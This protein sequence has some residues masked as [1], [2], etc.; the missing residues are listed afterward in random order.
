ARGLGGMKPEWDAA[1]YQREKRNF[2]ASR[3]L[4]RFV[5]FHTALIF[6][7]TWLARWALLKLGMVSMPLRYALAL[8]ASYLVWAPSAHWMSTPPRPIA[9]QASACA[10]RGG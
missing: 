8:I 7:A 3:L 10:V 5:Y 1:Q 4:W 2:I 9:L 6:G